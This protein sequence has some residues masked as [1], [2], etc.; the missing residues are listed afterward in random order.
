MERRNYSNGF[1]EAMVQKLLMP[2]AMGL[3]EFAKVN[4]VGYANLRRWRENYVKGR[5]MKTSKDKWTA[6]EKLRILIET[7]LMSEHELG[8]YLRKKGLHASDLKQWEEDSTSGLESKRGRPKKD[9]EVF[10]LRQ[11]KKELEKQL[12]RKDKALAE[13]SARV[14]LLKK[15][16]LIFQDTEDDES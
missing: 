7:S 13:M 6:K 12:R 11:Q 2:G 4:G 9:V 15:S 14:I 5:G 3:T 10:E 1:K 16:H 8:E